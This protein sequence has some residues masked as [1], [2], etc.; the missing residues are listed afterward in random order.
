LHALQHAHGHWLRHG[1]Q[2]QH[3]PHHVHGHW[4]GL[5]HGHAPVQPPHARA[6]CLPLTFCSKLTAASA[7]KGSCPIGYLTTPVDASPRCYKFFAKALTQPMANE[8]CR[9]LGAAVGLV[10]HLATITSCSEYQWVKSMSKGAAWICLYDRTDGAN[11]PQDRMCADWTWYS[12][13][14]TGFLTS[15]LGH[16]MW[17]YTGR[18]GNNCPRNVGTGGWGDRCRTGVSGAFNEPNN[19]PHCTN[20]IIL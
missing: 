17:D 4:H 12:G 19:W 5:Y 20:I 2:L 16:V 7:G 3:V 11:C 9:R 8:Q 18:V 14:S 10:G 1:L 13:E 6:L 15:P